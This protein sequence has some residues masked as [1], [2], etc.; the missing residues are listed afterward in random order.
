M[1][2]LMQAKNGMSKQLR[3]LAVVA[4]MLMAPMWANANV[5]NTSGNLA[6][7]DVE[8]FSFDVT[9]AGY[10]DLSLTSSS[11]DT[12]LFLFSSSVSFANFLESNDDGGSGYNSFIDRNLGLGRYVA[13]IGAYN[14]DLGEAV[15]G[16]NQGTSFSW[17]DGSGP[18]NL[19]ISSYNGIAV[20]RAVS[21]P[22]TIGLLGAG[23]IALAFVR[24]RK[25]A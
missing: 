15:S 25:S 9:D 11:F 10:F 24:R 6:F 17:S 12:Y 1:F 18:Y 16:V 7:G 5:I 3:N 21:E 19:R 2:N 14:L 4:A 22:G 23:L 8:Y 20:A 13:A